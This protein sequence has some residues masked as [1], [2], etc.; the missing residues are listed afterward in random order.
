M[1][2]LFYFSIGALSLVLF[3]LDQILMT[4][5]EAPTCDEEDVPPTN[6]VMTRTKSGHSVTWTWE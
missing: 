2:Q 5:P 6:A 4:E 1:R 3:L